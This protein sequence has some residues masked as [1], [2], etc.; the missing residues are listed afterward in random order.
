LSEDYLGGRSAWMK[1]V[2]PAPAFACCAH[3]A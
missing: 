3:M 1:L 2:V